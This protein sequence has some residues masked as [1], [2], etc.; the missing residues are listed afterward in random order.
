MRLSEWVHKIEP[1]QPGED[2]QG[3]AQ[4]LGTMSS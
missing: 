3:R 4:P 2:L 1:A